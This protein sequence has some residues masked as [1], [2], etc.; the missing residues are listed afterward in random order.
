MIIWKGLNSTFWGKKKS[1]N[2]KGKAK[3][4]LGQES[5]VVFYP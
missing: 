3:L 2:T 5:V 4:K 1:S